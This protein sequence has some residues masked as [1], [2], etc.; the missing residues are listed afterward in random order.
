MHVIRIKYSLF[1]LDLKYD[2]NENSFNVKVM[3]AIFTTAVCFEQPYINES[4]CMIS[5]IKARNQSNDMCSFD[6]K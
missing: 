1:H 4:Y 5:R 6:R 3:A 2:H